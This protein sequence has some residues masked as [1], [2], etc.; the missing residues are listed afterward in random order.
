MMTALTRVACP[1][2]LNFAEVR[3]LLRFI[4][5][6]VAPACLVSAAAVYFIPVQ[7]ETYS[8]A[9]SERWF[10]GHVIGAAITVPCMAT[11]MRPRR[12]MVFDRPAWE[13]ALMC[14]GVLVYVL[15][16]FGGHD[17]LLALMLFPLAMTVAFRY[18]PVGASAA[19]G[20]MLCVAVVYL[21][22]GFP[23]P[24]PPQRL[25]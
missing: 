24:R 9:V 15:R 13:L 25:R 16:V 20:L 6:A 8:F 17:P 12:F 21:Y 11:L 5:G 3:T 4:F 18:G 2:S 7:G 22:A 23:G 10:I 19:S 14:A 1:R